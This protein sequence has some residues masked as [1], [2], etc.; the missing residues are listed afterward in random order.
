MPTRAAGYA[1]AVTEQ[2]SSGP[3]TPPA[4]DAD[5]R[6]EPEQSPARHL[7]ETISAYEVDPPPPD[8]ARD[9]D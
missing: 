7:V 3:D 8:R 6:R 9:Q 5:D 4:P 1:A 2:S